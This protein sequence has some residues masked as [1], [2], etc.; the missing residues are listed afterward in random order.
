MIEKE[1]K[2]DRHREIKTQ[3]QDTVSKREREIEN[4]DRE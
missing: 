1:W 2:R 3:E 4:R